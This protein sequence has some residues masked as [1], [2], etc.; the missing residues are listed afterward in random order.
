MHTFILPV[1]V[2][3]MTCSAFFIKSDHFNIIVLRNISSVLTPIPSALPEP[4]KPT[5]EDAPKTKVII[6]LTI[7]DI[8]RGAIGVFYSPS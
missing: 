7:S 5:F 2:G 8:C 3:F 4:P 6:I 1:F